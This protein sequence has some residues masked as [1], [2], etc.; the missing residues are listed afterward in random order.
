MGPS[1]WRTRRAI[2]GSKH[3]TSLR[4]CDPNLTQG[5]IP[6]IY[7]ADLLKSSQQPSEVAKVTF[8][9]SELRHREVKPPLI[10]GQARLLSRPYGSGVHT[11][12]LSHFSGSE[13][14]GKRSTSSHPTSVKT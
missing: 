14:V 2:S 3:K 13:Q 9:R 10:C 5:A 1:S 11:R 12:N 4:V 6:S 7:T 8:C